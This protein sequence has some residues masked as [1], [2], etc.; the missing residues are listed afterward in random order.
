[1][2][3]S[4]A[5]STS[6]SEELSVKFGKRETN[7]PWLL[8]VGVS[9]RQQRTKANAPETACVC[10]KIHC[11]FACLSCHCSFYCSFFFLSRASLQQTLAPL[12]HF[13]RRWDEC[14]SFP[15]L[16]FFPRH[17]TNW[18]FAFLRIRLFP[19]NSTRSH[20]FLQTFLQLSNLLDLDLWTKGIFSC[21]LKL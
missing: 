5:G 13:R 21:F 14:L 6:I 3:W 17:S 20:W 11:V 7:P 12:S 19:D 15:S 16:T 9:H 8:P 10:E 1:M 18:D 4:F 2:T